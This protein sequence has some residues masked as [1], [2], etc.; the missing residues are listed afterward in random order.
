MGVAPGNNSIE[1]SEE[2]LAPLKNE[3]S[4]L[5]VEGKEYSTVLPLHWLTKFCF[6]LFLTVADADHL[7]VSCILS[8]SLKIDISLRR[9]SSRNKK[10]LLPLPLER[11]QRTHNVFSPHISGTDKSPI[12]P[13]APRCSPHI[14]DINAFG[15]SLGKISRIWANRILTVSSGSSSIQVLWEFWGSFFSKL[16]AGLRYLLKAA[17]FMLN[18]CND[19]YFTTC[20]YTLKKTLSCTQK[21][22]QWKLHEILCKISLPSCLGF[23]FVSVWGGVYFLVAPGANLVFAI[24]MWLLSEHHRPP[25]SWL[26]PLHR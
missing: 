2:I 10:L 13:K 26:N 5:D 19:L 25:N 15:N 24:E 6:L 23:H 7:W 21:V 9:L 12:A 4:S 3:I 18:C 17:I 11:P 22:F 14:R 1:T 20:T 8:E 16:Y